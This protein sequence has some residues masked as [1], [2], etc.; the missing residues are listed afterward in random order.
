LTL[1]GSQSVAGMQLGDGTN[2]VS[3]TIAAGTA[4][5]GGPGSLTLTPT[6]AGPIQ[7]AV[8]SGTHT[9]S[10]PVVLAGS[11]AVSTTAGGSLELSGSIGEAMV[12]GHAALTL[13][14]GKLIMSGTGSYLGGTTVSGGTL[15]VANLAALPVDRSLAVEAGGTVVFSSS[16]GL[17]SGPELSTASTSS[18]LAALPLRGSAAPLGISGSAPAPVPEPGTL[19]LLAAGASAGGLAYRRPKAKRTAS[20]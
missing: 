8:L 12:S 6:G 18:H 16:L 19:V 1:D 20:S 4:A 11:L 7:V 17:G 10:A 9:I 5:G 2:T 3:Y 15:L 14:G 13:S